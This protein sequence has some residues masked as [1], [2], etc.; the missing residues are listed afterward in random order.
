MALSMS[1]TKSSSP[2]LRSPNQ[3]GEP[4]S[5]GLAPP[6]SLAFSVEHSPPNATVDQ[7]VLPKV[8]SGDH[9]A[10]SECISRYGGLIWSIAKRYVKD[11][12]AAEDIV[13]EIFTA[14][15]RSASR[16]DPKVANE[17]TFVGMLARRRSIDFLRKQ[18]RRPELEPLPEVEL[19]PLASPEPSAST[20]CETSDVRGALSKLSED[21]QS[22]FSL[23]FDEG[24]T[25]SEIVERTGLPLGTV[26]TRLRR[27]LIQLRSILTRL[28]GGTPSS[29]ATS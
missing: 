10:M 19:L 23:H 24:M 15:W 13:Q 7:D 8:A 11:P 9:G 21:T 26:K 4:A 29:V 27:G 2:R 16:F 3:T 22:L 6:P 17:S 25:H 28:D 12:S 5:R 14:L 1:L 18:S 20:R